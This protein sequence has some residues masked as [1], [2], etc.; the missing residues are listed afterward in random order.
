MKRLLFIRKNKANLPEI[1]AYIKYFNNKKGYCAVDSS[2]LNGEFQLNDFDVIWEFKGF[3]G[4]KVKDQ[5]LIHEY[6]SL[7]T[8]KFLLLKN[9]MKTKFNYKPDLRIFLNEDVRR[10]FPF[11]DNIDFC[12]RDMGIDPGFLNVQ[13]NKK[14]YEFVYVGSISKDRHMDRLL[15]I[16]NEKK[17]G[18]ICLIGDVDPEIY[19]RF[20]KNKDFIFTGKV[21]YTQVPEIASKAIYGINYIPNKYPYNIQTSTKLLEYLALGLKVITTDYKWVRK[22]EQIHECSFYILNN[23]ELDLNMRLISDFQYVNKI[24]VENFLWDSIIKNSK[25]EHKIESLLK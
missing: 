22:F 13:N 19:S 12:Y 4:V 17:L 1:D 9:V 25:I 18:K 5:L 2:T 3:G 20:K 23:I 11:N 24:N 6:A 21:P 14:E 7:S 8:G 10:G 16:M 15:K